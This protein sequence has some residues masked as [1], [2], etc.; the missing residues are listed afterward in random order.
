[1]AFWQWNAIVYR[2]SFIHLASP[3]EC[4]VSPIKWEFLSFH[5]TSHHLIQADLKA[6]AMRVSMSLIQHIVV[7]IYCTNKHFP[8]LSLC[9]FVRSLASPPCRNPQFHKHPRLPLL[10][11]KAA[12]VVV[13]GC[14]SCFIFSDQPKNILIF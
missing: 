12:A 5:Y 7:I 8:F 9:R 2:H 10:I 6:S 4:A 14:C 13:V 11:L 3:L 1:M